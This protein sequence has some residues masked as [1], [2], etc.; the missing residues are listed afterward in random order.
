MEIAEY[1]TLKSVVIG[2]GKSI[3]INKYRVRFCIDIARGMNYLHKHDPSIIHR[4]LKS[5]NILV[6]RSEDGIP[7]AKVMKVTNS[8][9][10]STSCICVDFFFLFVAQISDFGLAVVGNEEMKDE[11]YNETCYSYLM[12]PERIEGHAFSSKSDVYRHVELDIFLLLNLFLFVPSFSFIMWEL[13]VQNTAEGNFGGDIIQ[14]VKEGLFFY[15]FATFYSIMNEYIGR[16]LSIPSECECKEY[17]QLIEEC[18]NQ[19][20]KKRPSFEVNR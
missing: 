9:V 7:I 4:D 6:C 15:L 19:D 11:L 12:P 20:P 5:S 2:N 18:W 16:R 13:L 14:F 17:V 1:G 3:D 8:L 10:F